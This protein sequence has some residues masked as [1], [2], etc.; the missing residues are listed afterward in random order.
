MASGARTFFEGLL[1]FVTP[2]SLTGRLL[3]EQELRA[4][5]VDPSVLPRACIDEFVNMI[6]AHSKERASRL[7]EYWKSEAVEAVEMTAPVI[8]GVMQG[9]LKADH[10]FF[11]TN[12]I[13]DVLRKHGVRVPTT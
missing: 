7:N 3:L 9:H 6:V 11:D 2:F 13:L 4:C 12:A 5:D 8:A 1:G 10:E